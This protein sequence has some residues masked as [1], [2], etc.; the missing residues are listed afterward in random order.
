MTDNSTTRDRI[1]EATLHLIAEKG[2]GSVAMSDIAS[3]AD[4]SRQTLYNHFGDVDTI[5]AASLAAHQRAALDDLAAILATI[6]A[7]LERLEHLVRHSG[8]VGVEHHPTGAIEHALSP[9]AR[10]ILAGYEAEMAT[11]IEGILD[12]GVKANAMRQDIDPARDARLIMRMLDGI[13]EQASADPERVHDIVA[14]ATRTVRA[15]VS[16][17][18]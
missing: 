16:R 5:V 7:P 9:D 8:A 11:L 14:S 10:S 12:S 15:A 13:V 4:I 3:R 6:A 1:V 2:L 18:G 17:V